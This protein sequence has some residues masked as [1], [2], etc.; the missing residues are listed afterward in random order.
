MFE[1][2]DFRVTV[3]GSEIIKGVTLSVPAGEVHALMGPNGSGKSTLAY[4]LSGP[5][6]Y[7]V[8]RRRATLNGADLLAMTPEERAAKGLFLSFQYPVEIP[9]LSVIAFLKAALNAQR[10]ARGRSRCR[11]RSF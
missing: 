7:E 2:K 3:G 4:A 8:T 10:V 5:R 6:R 9:G 11:R 1:L